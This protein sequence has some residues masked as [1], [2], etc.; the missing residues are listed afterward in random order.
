M[1]DELFVGIPEP[2]DVRRNLLES[3][4]D[5]I[6]CLQTYDKLEAIREQKLKYFKE[7][8]RVSSELDMLV[9]RLKQKLPQTIRK[10][11]KKENKKIV[12]ENLIKPNK[13]LKSDLQKLEEQ[14]QLI[15]EE[16]RSLK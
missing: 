16:L 15:E 8:K 2:I 10:L 14:L 7:M 13:K 4:K 11:E 12:E 5:L 6:K 3:S 9:N 1:T